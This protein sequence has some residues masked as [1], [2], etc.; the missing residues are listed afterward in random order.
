MANNAFNR[1]KKIPLKKAENVQQPSMVVDLN[2]NEIEIDKLIG[3]KDSDGKTNDDIFGPVT[4]ESILNLA[5]GIKEAGFKTAI[6]V[7]KLPDDKY[8]IYSG[9]RRVA[10]LKYLGRKVAKCDVYEYP[11]DEYDRRLQF[12]RANIHTRGS[13]KASTEGG[14][15][16]IAHQIKYLETILRAKGVKS[17]SE[18]D[19]IVC[20]EF[21]AKKIT[22]WKYK[23]LLKA[24]DELIE[25]EARGDIL[26]EQAASICVFSKEDQKTIVQAIEKTI[27][28]GNKLLGKDIDKLVKTIHELEKNNGEI[29]NESLN[30]AKTSSIIADIISAKLSNGTEEKETK[31]EKDVEH[32]ASTVY[33]KYNQKISTLK[34]ELEHNRIDD[35]KPEEVLK[36]LEEQEGLRKALDTAYLF[37]EL[38]SG[39]Y[40]E[41]SITDN[42]N[43]SNEDLQKLNVPQLKKLKKIFS[44]ENGFERIYAQIK[45]VESE[46]IMKGHEYD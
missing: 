22:I 34:N 4:E 10:A 5:N 24:C 6:E 11:N 35:L 30:Q 32:K 8:M 21:N 7:W 44:K 23:S 42:T 14:D 43:I 36:L 15:I 27:N 29:K 16:Y 26:I 37:A 31:A 20:E 39:K 28:D 18:V 19:K 46:I 33:E 41:E 40:K 1:V 17:Q 13:I 45:N 9:H 3:Y 38:I 25:A 2:T 12:L